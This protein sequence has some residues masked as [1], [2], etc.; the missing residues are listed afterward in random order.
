M[1]ANPFFFWFNLFITKYGCFIS[2]A[3]IY[4]HFQGAHGCFFDLCYKQMV[5]IFPIIANFSKF[6]MENNLF[7]PIPP[8]CPPVYKYIVK[9]ERLNADW[10]VGSH[11]PLFTAIITAKSSSATYYLTRLSGT[12][13][14]LPAIP[15]IHPPPYT[16][17]ITANLV[18]TSCHIPISQ[19]LVAF[20]PLLWKPLVKI[21]V[22]WA[23]CQGFGRMA[24]ALTTRT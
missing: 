18:S 11:C 3:S 9:S 13:H 16:P 7:F 20:G 6:K 21:K 17:Q 15:D 19:C 5:L 1:D 14:Y 12:R 22:R 2:I 23:V 24:E 8:P 10:W 4:T